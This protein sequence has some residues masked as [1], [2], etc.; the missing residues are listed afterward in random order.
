VENLRELNGGEKARKE[1]PNCHSKRN[2][3]DGKINTPS[4]STQRFYCRT[5]AY[6]FS[7][8]K[9]YKDSSLTDDCQLCTITEAKKLDTTTEIKT[10]VGDGK[11]NLIEYRLATE[12]TKHQR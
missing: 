11:T 7:V 5:C 4:G 8:E 3:K 9:S 1:C 12:K 2:W 10:V 6:R